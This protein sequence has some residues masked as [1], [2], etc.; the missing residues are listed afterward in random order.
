MGVVRD[1]LTYANAAATAGLFAALAGG[2]YGAFHVPRNSVRSA[3]IVNGQVRTADLARGAVTA[4]KVRPASLTPADV[5]LGSLPPGPTGDPGPQGGMGATG[6]TGPVPVATRLVRAGGQG[7]FTGGPWLL[8]ADQWTQ[9]AGETEVALGHFKVSPQGGGSCTSGQALT[10]SGSL[11]GR[12]FQILR[13]GGAF[14][15]ED[16]FVPPMALPAP[17]GDTAHS[18]QLSVTNTCSVAFSVDRLDIDV[19]RLG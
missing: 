12:S 14:V 4:R 1:R 6:A 3:T 17:T 5:A 18:L 15:D 2:A 13:I 10:V 19:V 9:R 7:P 16:D 8:A 11:D